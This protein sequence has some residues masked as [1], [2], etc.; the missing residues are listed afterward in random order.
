M[1][2]PA[3]L[4]I[5]GLF[6]VLRRKKPQ[7]YNVDES[8]AAQ[9]RVIYEAA[10]NSKDPVALRELSAA[11]RKEGCNIEADQLDKIVARCELPL[12]VKMARRDVFRKLMACTNP[13]QVREAAIVFDQNGC[14]GAAADLN[15]YAQGLED[16]EA[17][18]AQLQASQSQTEGMTNGE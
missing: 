2:I 15:R 11:F 6:A 10:L 3:I 18:A 7:G 12:D 9:R 17:A 16:A 8:T 14:Q 5:T 1:V 13:V 4:G